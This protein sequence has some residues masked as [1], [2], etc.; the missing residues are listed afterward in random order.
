MDN[1][2][3]KSIVGGFGGL[4]LWQHIARTTNKI[5]K[6]SVMISMVGSNIYN[7]FR[8]IG[9]KFAFVSSFLEYLKFKDI[10]ISIYEVISPSVDLIF[11]PFRGFFDGYL[12]Y[13][14]QMSS[15]NMIII[16]SILLILLPCLLIYRF[17]PGHFNFINTGIQARYAELC[18]KNDT[19]KKEK[20]Y[21]QIN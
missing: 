15:K 2:Y 20:R 7:L 1:I 6:P 16:G 14:T 4:V 9:N 19:P 10:G 5:I 18:K 17:F 11:S 13:I 12:K 21:R 8:I 3:I